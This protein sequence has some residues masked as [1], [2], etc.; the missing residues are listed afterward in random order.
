MDL[1]QVRHVF[2]ETGPFVTVHAEVGR[3]TEDGAVQVDARWNNV[4]QELE[5][6]DLDD[7]LVEDVG[8]RLREVVHA[9]GEARRTI[10]AA[11][12]RVLLDEVQV[13]HSLWPET[14]DVAALPD[15]SGWLTVADRAVPFV[16][17]VADREGADID[18]YQALSAG[19]SAGHRE[20]EGQTFQIHKVPVGGWAQD[21]YQQSVENNWHRNAREVAAAVTSLLEHH[22]S[23]LV[24]LAGDVRARA[25]LA[26]LLEAPGTTLLQT[27]AGGRAPGASQEAL[28][29]AVEE[30]LA[31][32]Q[33]TRERDLAGELERARGQ[34]AGAAFGLQ[35]VLTALSQSQVDRL[36]LDL[37]AAAEHTVR[38]D[39]YPGLS[40]PRYALEGEDLP[41]DRVLVAAAALTG[42]SVHLLPAA[43]AHGGG[44]A[45]QL[46]WVAGSEA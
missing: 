38:P 37:R 1:Q 30:A 15:L 14:T 4:R 8:E 13:G 10:V 46:R 25:D 21:H 20:V 26:E 12:G 44:I 29:H 24:V 32:V 27:E 18:A 2:E 41:A 33:A 36:A 45:A 5:Q 35:D 3:T 19:S 43:L 17:V 11:A 31:E 7:S 16:L 6:H 9:P 22:R 40:L 23:E 28:W 34:G 39:R 42:A